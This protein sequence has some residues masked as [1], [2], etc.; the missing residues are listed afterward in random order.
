MDQYFDFDYD[1]GHVICAF[2]DCVV[3]CVYYDGGQ[4]D[5]GQYMQCSTTRG[6]VIFCTNHRDHQFHANRSCERFEDEYNS[7]DDDDSQ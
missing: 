3:R 2:P 1:I 7:E 5:L 4:C 6:G